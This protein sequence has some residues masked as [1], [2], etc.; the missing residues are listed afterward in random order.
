[1]RNMGKRLGTTITVLLRCSRVN[2][3]LYRIKRAYQERE[4]A[5]NRI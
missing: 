4:L 1:M 2:G 3:R 5:Y